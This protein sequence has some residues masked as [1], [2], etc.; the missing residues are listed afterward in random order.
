MGVSPEVI[1]AFVQ[2]SCARQGFP[3]KVTDLAV[4]ARLA[5]LLRGGAPGDG[6]QPGP[7]DRP[8]SESPDDLDAIPVQFSGPL[9]AGSDDDVVD[10][11][12]DDG[13]L[14]GEVELG[15]GPA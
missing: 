12:S 2:A 6:R 13:G 9:G 15:P 8:R 7:D 10:D 14:A 1:E 3:V 11:R 4:V 5:V